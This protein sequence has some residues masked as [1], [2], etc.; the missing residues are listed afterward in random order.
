MTL[1]SNA[2]ENEAGENYFGS[3]GRKKYNKSSKENGKTFTGNI[4]MF[5]E[6]KQQYK[7]RFPENL[8]CGKFRFPT[9]EE[10]VE[11]PERI[12]KDD[13]TIDNTVKWGEVYICEICGYIFEDISKVDN[14][15]IPKH[16]EDK[17]P[18]EEEIFQAMAEI[19]LLVL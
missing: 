19:D 11:M 17:E 4:I 15:E 2:I 10:S 18:T 9:F 12:S 1:L 6:N 14:V 8:C 13:C 7:K 16:K 5:T 3:E